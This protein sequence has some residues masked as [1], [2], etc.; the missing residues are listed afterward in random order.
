MGRE[1]VRLGA[2]RQDVAH[3]DGDLGEGR[4]HVE[5]GERERRDPVDADREAQGRQVEPAAAPLPAGD[6]AE[7]AA[8]RADPLLR[9]TLDLGRERPVA[10]ARDVGL[11]D[12]ED[13]VDAVGPI[14]KLT[15][16]PAAMGLDEVTNG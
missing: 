13:L 15:A 3:A 11:G 5:L 8:E 7:L 6:G 10:D 16:A 9:L 12:A 4:E 2:V 14:P 1:V